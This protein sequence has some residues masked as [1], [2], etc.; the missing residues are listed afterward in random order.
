MNLARVQLPEWLAGLFALAVIAGLARPWSGGETALASPGFFDV[1][2]LLAAVA[3][4]LLPLIVASS[5]RTGLPVVY[6][7]LLWIVLLILILVLFIKAFLPPEGGYDTGFWI[8]LAGT[9]LLG[10]AL[11]RSVGRES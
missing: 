10:L 4:L 9:F 7:T 5:P 1:V 3:A 8:T 6:E 11:W 2:L